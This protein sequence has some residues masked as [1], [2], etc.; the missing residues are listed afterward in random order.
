[1]LTA[2]E[3]AE[4]Y[5]LSL[6][7][8]QL[9]AVQ[10]T[11]GPVLLLAV[12]GSGKTT[13]LVARLGYMVIECGIP[14]ESILTMTYTVSAAKE[15]KQRF[16]NLFGAEIANRMEFRTINSVCF[17]IIR[18]YERMYNR[19][20]FKLIQ[21]GQQSAIVGNIYRKQ[22][23]NFA[24]DSMVK[25][26]LLH[27]GYAKNFMMSGP[28]LDT[29]AM[30]DG[31]KFRPFFE[32][33]NDILRE[34]KLMDFDDQL[35]YALQLLK[36]R[37]KLLELYQKQYTYICVD[38]SQDTS[39]I[40]HT[41]IRLLAKKH[42]NLF[43]VGDEDQSIY[44]FRAAYPEALMNFSD[45]FPSVK[46]LLLEKNYRSTPAIVKSANS[47]IAQNKHR[48]KKNMIPVKDH[49]CA[50]IEIKYA[51]RDDQISILEQYAKI[52]K[53]ETAILYRNNSSG[54]PIIDMLDKNNIPFRCK[55]MDGMF[56]STPIVRDFTNIIRLIYNPMDYDA[57]LSVYPRFGMMLKKQI[58][59]EATNRAKRA[60][61][62][63]FEV[64]ENDELLPPCINKSAHRVLS[65]FK[66][67]KKIKHA[68][69]IVQEIYDLW[70]VDCINNYERG[71]EKITALRMLGRNRENGLQLLDRLEELEIIIRQDTMNEN[72]SLILST[73]HSSKGLEYE[74][75]I[76]VD[77]ID[78]I[79]PYRTQ[80]I[81]EE[82][83]KNLEED[84]R[85]FYVGI[86]RAKSE[87]VLLNI[88]PPKDKKYEGR[89]YKKSTFINQV[90]NCQKGA[91]ECSPDRMG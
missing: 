56:F 74:R 23:G 3:F 15:M 77:V 46:T 90:M 83:E 13:S 27:I 88:D 49:G 61:K 50:I 9:D 5:K 89:R 29:F 18:S 43:M 57:F 20:A 63:P 67:I 55:G 75:V 2:Q 76:M 30:D 66:R 44:A 81:D 65:L 84:R 39:K 16:I 37:P 32:E 78:G 82:E 26:L 41:I 40:Q 25:N 33:Y 60:K 80:P 51:E 58:A 47:F 36:S 48:H 34:N 17:R 38:E 11:E 7:E 4:E 35:C 24:T 85:T 91:T 6:N 71:Y 42:G 79:L 86:T 59:L 64:I 19:E 54:L 62:S 12:P 21:P 8:Q 31:L 72:V 70:F 52:V 10:H 14:P 53:T 68:D 28:E 1:M 22:T 69:Q 45:E 87:L 73:I